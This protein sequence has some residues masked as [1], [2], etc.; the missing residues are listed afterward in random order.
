VSESYRFISRWSRLKHRAAVPLAAKDLPPLETLAADADLSAYLGLEI[1]PSLRLQALKRIFTDPGF[2]VM[3][4]LDVYIDDYSIADPIPTEMLA[5]MNQARLLFDEE[6]EQDR[7]SA[8]HGGVMADAAA[9]LPE[10]AS[11]P[12]GIAHL[13][14]T[15]SD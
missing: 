14:E 3:D 12:D 6:G 4:G 5:Q 11:S 9:P 15:H 13:E 1:D 7:V 10:G 8:R 2:N